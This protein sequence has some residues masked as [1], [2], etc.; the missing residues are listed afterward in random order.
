MKIKIAV[1]TILATL[2]LWAVAQNNDMNNSGTPP[3]GS[4]DGTHH[5]GGNKH[6]YSSTNSDSGYYHGG[7]TNRWHGNTNDWNND[8]MSNTNRHHWKNKDESQNENPPQN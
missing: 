1:V 8:G 2:S 5:Y 7:N 6:D 3:D 4:T